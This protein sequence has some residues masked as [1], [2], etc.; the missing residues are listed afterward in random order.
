MCEKVSRRQTYIGPTPH[1]DFK[2]LGENQQSLSYHIRGSHSGVAAVQNSSR[3]L[4][5]VVA[6]VEYE[7]SRLHAFVCRV[8]EPEMVSVYSFGMYSLFVSDRRRL[9]GRCDITYLLTPWSRVLLKKLSGFQ[10]VKKVPEFYGTRRII[11]SVTGARYL[12]LS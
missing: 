3:M 8:T 6:F 11:T 2:Q 1:P 10:L 12:S 7:V 9:T 4:H 5:C